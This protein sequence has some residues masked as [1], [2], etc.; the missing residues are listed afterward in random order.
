[1]AKP[2]RDAPVR[3]SFATAGERRAHW[4]IPERLRGAD[5]FDAKGLVERLVEPWLSAAELTWRPLRSAALAA[6]AAA[7]VEAP[8]GVLLGVAGLLS[9]DERRR[10]ELSVPV[11][12]GEI[13]LSALPPER[14]AYE[15]R[16]APLH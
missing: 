12:A 4:S 15:F 3:A 1:P 11:F 8:G 6:G 14:R 7:S 13:V 10:R 5:F 2:L 16:E 9:E